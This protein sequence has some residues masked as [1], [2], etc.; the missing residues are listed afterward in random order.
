MP[1]ILGGSFGLSVVHKKGSDL[2]GADNIAN[3]TYDAGAAVK[4]VVVGNKSLHFVKDYTLSGNVITF[5]MKV[6]NSFDILVLT[7]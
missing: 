1:T 3:R 6:R 5:K 4:L 2:T 7:Q